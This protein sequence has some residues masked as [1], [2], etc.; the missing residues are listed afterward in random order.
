MGR[1]WMGI[2]AGIFVCLVLATTVFSASLDT[3]GE[4]CGTMSCH[5]KSAVLKSLTPDRTVY[6]FEGSCGYWNYSSDVACPPAVQ[7]KVTGE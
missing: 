5:V 6:E 1:S 7:V 2:I 4:S 3:Q